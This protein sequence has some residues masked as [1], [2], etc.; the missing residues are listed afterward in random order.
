MQGITLLPIITIHY[1]KMC[2]RLVLWNSFILLSFELEHTQS[3]VRY[4][5]YLF[6][7]PLKTFTLEMFY[8]NHISYKVLFLLETI[9]HKIGSPFT[10]V[11]FL[12]LSTELN[13]SKYSF[14]TYMKNLFHRIDIF[15]S[16]LHILCTQN[17]EIC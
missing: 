9:Y 17:L 6:I 7:V 13:L 10:R 4:I 12:W 1:T 11:F 16:P 5:V 3:W 2:C 15:Y 14:I 8:I